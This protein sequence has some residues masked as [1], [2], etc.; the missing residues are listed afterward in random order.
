MRFI[1]VDISLLYNTLY[2]IIIIIIII[3]KSYSQKKV[4]NE[5]FFFNVPAYFDSFN[6]YQLFGV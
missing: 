4:S 1:F 3:D 6:L 5:K 2:T